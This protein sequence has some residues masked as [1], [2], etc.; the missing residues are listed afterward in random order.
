MSLCSKLKKGLLN[1]VFMK[2]KWEVEIASYVMSTVVIPIVY[3]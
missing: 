3:F 2:E 1:E